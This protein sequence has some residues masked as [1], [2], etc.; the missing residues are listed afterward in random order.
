MTDKELYQRIRRSNSS[1][2]WL[3]KQYELLGNKVPTYLDNTQHNEQKRTNRFLELY[4][5]HY[6][7]TEVSIDKNYKREYMYYRRHGKC[8]WEIE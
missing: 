4:K 2:M 3:R 6:N 7:I 1:R 5:K 8:R